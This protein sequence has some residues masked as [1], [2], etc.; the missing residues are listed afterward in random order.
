MSVLFTLKTGSGTELNRPSMRFM[1]STECPSDEE[2]QAEERTE[3]TV[4]T[5]VT[6]HR[7]EKGTIVYIDARADVLSEA[8]A[9]LEGFKRNLAIVREKAKGAESLTPIPFNN[10]S[11]IEI[12]S[13]IADK[14]WM[15][16]VNP[17]ETSNDVSL[18]PA[19]VSRT[20]C[21][22]VAR[23]WTGM[24]STLDRASAVLRVG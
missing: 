16:K 24:D 7:A 9:E 22:R 21:N 17:M 18:D 23:S 11:M 12:S 10:E 13:P 3:A 8:E 6:E 19:T 5:K 4:L 2:M 15:G 1:L 14:S 20:I